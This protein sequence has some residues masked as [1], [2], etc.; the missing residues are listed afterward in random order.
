LIKKLIIYSGF[1][2]LLG[3]W[4]YRK[5]YHPDETG[6]YK[7]NQSDIVHFDSIRG[8]EG[9]LHIP[10]QVFTPW[11]K[12]AKGSTSRVA[13]LLTDTNSSWLALVHG[14]KSA[15]IP[16]LVTQN[17][18]AALKHSMV[19][20]YPTLS[21][22][23]LNIEALRALAEFPRKGGILVA[24]NVTSEGISEVF[25]FKKSA[26]QYKRYELRFER[27]VVENSH[28]GNASNW[29]IRLGNKEAGADPI[30]STSY[31]SP[32]NKP[33]AYYEDNSA[34]I[35]VKPYAK[36]RSYAIGLDLG[37]FLH[38]AY[39]NIREDLGVSNLLQISPTADVLMNL[40]KN[41]YQQNCANAV[42]I[43]PIP[44]NKKLSV[45]LTHNVSSKKQF[46]NALYFAHFEHSQKIKS[47]YFIQAKYISD[48]AG[49]AFITPSNAKY[50]KKMVEWGME[51]GSQ[52]VT[53][54]DKF[55]YL[56][57][58]TGRESYPDYQPYVYDSRKVYNATIAG[59]LRVSK[60][61]LE[62]VAGVTVNSFRTVSYQVP[63]SLPQLLKASKY[64][65]SS[66]TTTNRTYTHRPFP[67]NYGYDNFAETG[68]FEFPVTI[69]DEF[70]A[71]QLKEQ[72]GKTIEM[73][74]E[75]TNFQGTMLI[76]LNPDTLA[77][78]DFE[79]DLI[80]SVKEFSWVGSL[81]DYA[82]FW[83]AR[84]MVEIDM[85][86][87]TVLE[88]NAPLAITG[89]TIQLPVGWQM[90]NYE[91]LGLPVDQYGDKLWFYNFKGKARIYFTRKT[92]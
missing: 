43:S 78:L 90:Y 91:P 26:P 23:Y 22:R 30:A 33:L 29:I 62:K 37:Y 10:L 83:K 18:K 19:V 25:G 44:E 7:V 72:F 31:I 87:D 75:L 51:I 82:S 4:I 42:T 52:S 34:A 71:S 48:Y 28:M 46:F 57:N 14:F 53:A 64:Q 9:A 65:Y 70:S 60:F 61:L 68:L 35:T 12:F 77:K 15:G 38:K 88:V 84:D 76:S 3:W 86:D 11:T 21:P 56:S 40:L 50:L 80:E 45:V 17:Y 73:A 85:K 63:Q 66:S 27:T 8:P 13:I 54:T 92:L 32:L 47:T 41:I 36:G 59:E 49:V 6:I 5:L 74:Y 20:V 81:N 2:L 58:G 67:L 69:N 39:N 1:V 79:K 24:F 89:L 55:T 16:F